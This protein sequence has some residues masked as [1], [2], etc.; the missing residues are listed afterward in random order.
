MSK[1]IPEIVNFSP[2]KEVAQMMTDLHGDSKTTNPLV[3]DG[4]AITNFRGIAFTRTQSM[5][6]RPNFSLV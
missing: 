3:S 6:T 2:L 1:F 5:A 4:S